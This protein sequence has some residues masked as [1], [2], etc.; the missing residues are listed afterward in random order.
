MSTLDS[1]L[2]TQSQNY[3]GY[4]PVIISYS[5]HIF[6][7]CTDQTL[8]LWYRYLSMLLSNIYTYNIWP[9]LPH[10]GVYIY[11]GLI[12]SVVYDTLCIMFPLI[13]M[14]LQYYIY[15]QMSAEIES[16]NQ[17]V[18]SLKQELEV[19]AALYLDKANRYQHKAM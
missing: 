2:L 5:S 11:Y 1:L 12:W 10:H 8:P 7:I 3:K 17:Q 13:I 9:D 19:Q 15:T 18:Q 4:K 6:S 16:L 14:S